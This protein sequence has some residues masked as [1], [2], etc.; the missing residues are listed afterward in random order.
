MKNSI[1]FYISLVILI[2]LYSCT[3]MDYKYKE[4]VED[5]PITYLARLKE[6]EV[7]VIGGRNRVKIIIPAQNDPR[8]TKAEVYWSNK[9][10]HHVEPFDPSRENIFFINDL[11]EASYI[12]EIAVLNDKGNFSLPIAKSATVY[13]STWESY[14]SNRIIVGNV[15]EGENRKISF[16]KNR[17]A[18]LI[19]TDFEWKQNGSTTPL[20]TQIDSSQTTGYLNDF[21]AISFRYRTRYIPEAGGDDMFY[22]PWEYYIENVNIADVQFDKATSSFTLPQPNDGNW[23]GYEFLWTDKTTGELKS[24]TTSTNTITLQNYNGISVNYRTLYKFDDVSISSVEQAFSTVRYV[25]LDRSSWYAAP[26]TRISDGSSLSNTSQ[27]QVVDK[28]KSPYLSHLLFY[29]ASGT[30]GQNAPW[31]HFDNNPDTYMALVKGFG[32]TLQTNRNKTGTAHSIG[33]VASDGND[34]YFIIDLGVKKDFNYFRILY[35]GGQGNGNLKPQ[36]LS[37]FGSND[38]D[39]ITDQNKWNTIKETVELPGRDQPSN[40]GDANHIGKVTGNVVLPEGSFRYLKVRYDGW[41]D[42]SNTMCISEFYLGLYN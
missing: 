5:G 9:M 16:E 25:D 7:Q 27:A 38:P 40:T 26:E 13:G 29:A 28:N 35:R 24:Q 36:I 37:F 4:F 19:G 22:S 17:D 34:V 23:A 1:S 6:A 32:T 12:F 31:A 2:L 42:A 14:I 20:T 33:G 3:P 39:C 18:R 30:D 41:T 21:K 11:I 15:K 8:S 10:G